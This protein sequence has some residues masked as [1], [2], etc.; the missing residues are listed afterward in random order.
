MEH[1]IEVDNL[2]KSFGDKTALKGISF[3]VKKGEIFGFLGPSGSGKTTTIKILTSQLWHTSGTV[4]VFGQD[5]QSLDPQTFARKI[6]ILTDNSGLY[7]RLTV[8]DNLKLFAQLYGV[9]DGQIE[10][11]LRDVGLL[12][13]KRKTVKKL[14]KGMKQRVTL[15]RAILHQPELLFL[16]EPTAS[17]DPV[18]IQHVHKVLRRLNDSGTTIF[19]TTHNM[20]EAEDLCDRVSFLNEGTISALDT[21][22]NLRLQYADRTLTLYL[23]NG[24]TR[25]VPQNREGAQV[26]YDSMVSE[27]LRA[28]H[29]NEPTLGDIFV[30]LTGRELL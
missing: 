19:L 30:T 8:Y 12:G 11:V 27:R 7:E 26:V 25:T 4:S 13:E 15:A 10:R 3:R 14:S 2:V 28:I 20:Q 24:E 23:D 9:D 21:P 22:Q 5:V 18:T 29:S 17:L 1:V 6:G 16:D